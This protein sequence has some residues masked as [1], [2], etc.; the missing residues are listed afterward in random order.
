[1][2]P[3]GRSQVELNQEAAQQM[4]DAKNYATKV[5]LEEAGYTVPNDNGLV[6]S[7]LFVKLPADKV[8]RLGDI[9][10][11]ADG[12]TI[13][14]NEDLVTAINKHKVGEEVALGIQRDGKRQTVHVPVAEGPERTRVVI[15]VMGSPRYRFPVKVSVDT[16]GI[17]GPSA[18]LAMSLAI[19]D[20]LTPGNLTGGQKV[21]VTGTIDPAGN[22]GPIG[23]I[24]QKA[25]AARSSGANLFLVPKCSPDLAA[26]AM[27]AC[28]DELQ[29]AA[30]R[31]GKSVRVIPVAT[32]DEAVAALRDA[33]GDPV[34]PV[35]PRE[36]VA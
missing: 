14:E 5:A 29:Q 18:G 22:V 13:F 25:I 21:A 27:Q 33:G 24:A 35:A 2:N 12:K 34:T 16:R 26:D 32:F 31:A 19:L 1:L 11:T 7:G 28:E 3:D 9:I 20:D 36:R 10:L 17:G 23:G 30:D 6:V 4:A 8:L 15:G